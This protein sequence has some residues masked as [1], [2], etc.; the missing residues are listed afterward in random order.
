MEC[1]ICGAESDSLNHV[2][3]PGGK[4]SWLCSDCLIADM[5]LWQTCMEI[6][7]KESPRKE[8]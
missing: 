7:P 8:E 2:L 6:Q 4:D 1:L 3:W 5:T